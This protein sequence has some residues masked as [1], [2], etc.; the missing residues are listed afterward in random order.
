MSNTF[1]IDANVRNS[2]NVNDTNNRFTYKLPNALELPTNTEIALQSSIIN[3]QGITGASLEIQEDYED[4]VIYQYYAMDTSYPSPNRTATYNTDENVA[5]MLNSECS[6]RRNISNGEFAGLTYPLNDNFNDALA[7]WSEYPMPL[8]GEIQTPDGARTA[9]PM[10]GKS[11]IKIPKGIYS[12]NQLGEEITRQ[13]N[14]SALPNNRNQGYYDDQRRRGQFTGYAANNSTLRS[15]KVEAN[16]FWKDLAAGTGNFDDVTR[17]NQDFIGATDFQSFNDAGDFDGYC[18]VIAVTGNINQN[19]INNARFNGFSNASRTAGCSFEDIVTTAG[20]FSQYFIGWEKRNGFTNVGANQRI[21]DFVDDVY[22]PFTLGIGFGTSQFEVKYDNEES[23]FSINYAHEPRKI[24]TVDRYGNNMDN[25]GQECIY[26]KKQCGVVNTDGTVSQVVKDSLTNVVQKLSG[27]L[28]TNWAYDTCRK[29]GNALDTFQYTDNPDDNRKN[30]CDQYRIY[31]DFFLTT[32]D[33]RAAWDNTIW[34]RLGFQYD[35]IQNSNIE[36]AGKQT[37]K[38]YGVNQTILG[39]MTN[40]EIDNT[41]TPSV[42][43]LFNPIKTKALDAGKPVGGDP[44]PKNRKRGAL[45]AVSSVQRFMLWGQNIP[46]NIFNNITESSGGAIET[47]CVAPYKGSFYKGAVMIPVLT[48][49]RPFIASKLPTLSENGYL[50]IT[51]DIVEANDILKNQQTD[52][53]LDLIPKSSLSNQ[54]YMADRNIISH[55]LSNPKSINEITIKILNPDMTDVSLSPNS[56]FLLRVTLP[57]PKPT[58]FIFDEELQAKEN[59]VGSVVQNMIASHTDPNKAQDNIRID[60]SN[61]AAVDTGGLGVAEDPVTAVGQGI[62]QQAIADDV[63]GIPPAIPQGGLNP[64]AEDFPAVEETLE[65]NAAGALIAQQQ[66]QLEKAQG[67]QQHREQVTAGG[68]KPR[69]LAQSV[70]GEIARRRADPAPEYREPDDPRGLRTSDIRRI[71]PSQVLREPAPL[72][73]DEEPQPEASR[74]E[75][76]AS[77]FRKQTARMERDLQGAQR[78]LTELRER[79]ARAQ[80]RLVARGRTPREQL[81][82]SQEIERTQQ[83]IREVEGIIRGFGG[84]P[85]PEVRGIGRRIQVRPDPKAI[86]GVTGGSPRQ[87]RRRARGQEEEEPARRV[88]PGRLRRQGGVRRAGDSGLGATPPATQFAEE[89]DL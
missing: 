49:G 45:P 53:I 26:L 56:T 30:Q 61:M 50:L 40:Q 6:D 32:E 2:V 48:K 14:V 68:K 25:A 59:Q 55:T 82:L 5:Y 85:D 4:T 19:L 15:F 75:R 51:S 46:N 18:S 73:P 27:I 81:L 1:Y 66:Q 33:A 76:R 70:L 88:E 37:Y 44:N 41:I 29:F 22:N 78:D 87:P 63:R 23:A 10:L 35:D 12:I 36:G 8:I 16:T 43:T 21:Y 60:I 3:L 71:L 80:G 65:L 54:D 58:N 17:N 9:V 34:A 72:R 42:S 20:A 47:L 62:I 24:P 11:K 52:G 31:D 57:I 79:R 7:G 74:E 67:D 69:S 84:T 38:Q 83:R 64:G 13:I 77:S 28:I 39:F 86:T 89:D